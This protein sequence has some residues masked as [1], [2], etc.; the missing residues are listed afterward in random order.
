MTWIEGLILFSLFGFILTL[1]IYFFRLFY[2]NRE[3]RK[4]RSFLASEFMQE[5][6][7][8]AIQMIE[9]QLKSFLES[10]S[11]VNSSQPRLK[12]LDEGFEKSFE[13]FKQNSQNK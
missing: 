5:H 12:F 7:D 1:G 4:I 11:H 13:E 9:N 10:D 2:F 3:G 6:P 8:L